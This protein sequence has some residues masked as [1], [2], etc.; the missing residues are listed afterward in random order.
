MSMYHGPC[1]KIKR[2][3]DKHTCISAVISQAEH[4]HQNSIRLH[5]FKGQSLQKWVQQQRE[6][7]ASINS[8]PHTECQPAHCN[9]HHCIANLLMILQEGKDTEW[10]HQWPP[11]VT[12][13]KCAKSIKPLHN[14]RLISPSRLNPLADKVAKGKESY[15]GNIAKI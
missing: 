12:A 14:R 13:L 2:Q 5:T 15:H 1:Y 6:L 4:F 7:E 10:W 8:T 11:V 3:I 9:V